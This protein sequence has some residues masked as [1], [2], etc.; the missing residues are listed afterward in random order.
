VSERLLNAIRATRRIVTHDNCADGLA[1]ALLC[2][3]AL[4]DAELV[5]VQYNTVV[6]KNLAPRPGTLFV[7]MTPYVERDKKVMTAAGRAQAQAWVEAGAV[8]LDHHDGAKDL[9]DMFGELGV[10]AD[11]ATE[12]Q[13]SVSGAV[14]AHEHVWLAGDP[15]YR[16]LE[17]ERFV[18]LCGIRDTWCTGHELWRTACAQAAHLMFWPRKDLLEEGL[19]LALQR[20][21]DPDSLGKVLL[22]KQEEALHKV[23]KTA[24]RVDV[25][26]VRAIM[27]QGDSQ[28]ASD[29]MEFCGD[30]ADAVL[31]WYYYCDT[32]TLYIKVSVRSRGAFSAQAFAQYNNGNGHPKAAGFVRDCW[33]DVNPYTY[34]TN[35]LMNFIDNGPSK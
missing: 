2:K 13:R 33:G 9:V 12:A 31:A 17:L 20:L 11:N 29:L 32:N 15:G 10:Y 21:S 4:P 5:F 16:D 25:G 27:F 1:A 22:Q 28:Q 3:A 35:C 30:T 7:D 18:K 14:L 19:S 23:L 34:L 24:Y 26:G 6:H 8:V